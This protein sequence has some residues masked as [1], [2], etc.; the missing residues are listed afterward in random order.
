MNGINFMNKPQ[1]TE[2]RTKSR[3]EGRLKAAIRRLR[4]AREAEKVK[5]DR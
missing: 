4:M 5:Q 3:R 1:T 2:A